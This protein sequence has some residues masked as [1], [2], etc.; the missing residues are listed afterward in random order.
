MDSCPK[1]P[2][3]TA[4][5]INIERQTHQRKKKPFAQL[6]AD[7][8][9][10]MLDVTTPQI[11]NCFKQAAAFS[12]IKPDSMN[13]DEK[14]ARICVNLL[15]EVVTRARN[16]TAIPSL[17][18]EAALHAALRLDDNY[19]FKENDLLDIQHSAVAVAYCNIHLTER[20]FASKLCLPVVQ[21]VIRSGC[22]IINDLDEA[23]SIL[24]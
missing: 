15:R 24:S 10:G 13:L 19:L 22:K 2:A 12:G 3:T 23:I 9:H 16:N 21:K 4:A 6:F 17:R 1:T 18:I 5:R 14:N 11:E 20:Q 8:L 7:E